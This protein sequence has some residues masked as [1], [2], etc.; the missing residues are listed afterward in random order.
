MR[1]HRIET[2]EIEAV[3]R[4]HPRN[5]QLRRAR[6][7]GRQRRRPRWW[8]TCVRA[9]RQPCPGHRTCATTS[10]RAC[11]TSWCRRRR[12]GSDRLPVTPTASWI[13]AR[14]PEPARQRPNWPRPYEARARR[15]RT[16]G[17]RAV[18]R[19]AGPRQA[20]A[21]TTTSSTWAATRCWCCACWRGCRA[22][23]PARCRPTSVFQQRPHARGPGTRCSWQR[24][25][26]QPS[27]A[28]TAS[29]RRRGR[30][31]AE[32]LAAPGCTAT[33]RSPSSPWPGAS[34]APRRRAVLATT[35][36]RP[37]SI[38]FFEPRRTR[39]GGARRELRADPGYVA[40][41]GVIDG[42]EHVRRGVLR[43]QPARSR[44]DGSAAAR[45]SSSCA[46]N[47]WSAPAT[48]PTPPPGPVGVFAGMY[49]ATYFQRHV[50]PVAR[51]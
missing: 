8:P 1:G 30:C 34:P 48:R 46:G 23:A 50:S 35:C 40:A 33:S 37:R 16:A 26:P 11:P 44:A 5:A 29:A 25:T 6:P 9:R 45:S 22:P 13:A 10:P 3:L 19:R 12:S 14:L 39:P 32:P 28:A 47:A 42:V 41:R 38:T 2:G 15:R 20:S 4:A 24:R 51:T 18:R 43:H 49:N 36:A 31:P 27:G 17:V 7:Q 21:G